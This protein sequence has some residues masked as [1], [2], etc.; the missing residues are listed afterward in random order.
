MTKP[1][2]VDITPL[3]QEVGRTSY[4]EL[5]E[6]ISGGEDGL[7]IT[8]PVKI[9]VDLVNAGGTILVN[10]NAK[11]KVKVE[12][13]RCLDSFDLPME[14]NF[15]EEYSSMGPPPMPKKKEVELTNRDFIFRIGKDN[16]IDL[17]EAVREN[18]ITELPIKALCDKCANPST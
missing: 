13:A 12:C 7:I 1:L 10:V 8:E 5:T 2:K 14:I 18:L 17:G 16:T 9:E 6:K 15:E 4:L 3:L 11:T